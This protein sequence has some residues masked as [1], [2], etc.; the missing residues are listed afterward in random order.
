MQDKEGELLNQA[1]K[2]GNAFRVIKV[3]VPLLFYAMRISVIFITGPFALTFYLLL[4]Q[5]VLFFFLVLA[6]LLILYYALFRNFN[7]PAIVKFL[8]FCGS[9]AFLAIIGLEYFSG[10]SIYF[11]QIKEIQSMVP[12]ILLSIVSFVVFSFVGLFLADKIV[13]LF[14]GKENNEVKENA[15]MF[16][17]VIGG[18]IAVFIMALAVAPNSWLYG[19]INFIFGSSIIILHLSYIRD[20]LFDKK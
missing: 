11:S 17:A 8:Q 1:I 10:K 18:A 14:G 3:I 4:N 16:G 15:D 13:F 7:A 20:Y 5:G 6:L 12:F 19:Y 9:A 2:G